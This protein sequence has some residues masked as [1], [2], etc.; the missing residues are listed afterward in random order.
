MLIT[1]IIGYPME[2]TL[3]PAMH[4]AAF[5]EL[6]MDAVYVRL[7][8]REE[9]LKEAIMGLKVLG[10]R[11][12]NVT[13]PYKEKVI[14]YLDDIVNGAKKIGAVNTIVI[15]G[16]KLL[17][18]NTDI[19]GF[20]ESLREYKINVTD[21]NLL[22]IG[23]GGA[24][25]ACAYVIDSMKPKRFVIT[26]MIFEKAKVLS[27]TYDAE[28]IESDKIR[29]IIPEMDIVI[30]A[31]PEDLQAAVLSVMRQGVVYYDM[32]YK[33]KVLR[34][35]GVKVINGLL[36]L[37]LQGARAFYLWTGRREPIEIMKKA[38]GVKDD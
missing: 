16:D 37:V 13:I 32:N 29:N 7:P 33:F 22:L 35:G 19:Y 2:T 36:M 5:K 3:S 38:A 28:V 24:A 27:Q 23:A 11:G 34:K 25:R 20:K 26:D 17:G 12:V 31:T 21:N 6:Q 8:V 18:H 1:G 4:N 30:N 10:F 9:R 15:E 14:E